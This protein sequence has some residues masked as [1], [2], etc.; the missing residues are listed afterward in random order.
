MKEQILK[1]LSNYLELLQERFGHEK[2][3]EELLISVAEYGDSDIYHNS[4]KESLEKILEVM[5]ID[6]VL[7]ALDIITDKIEGFPKEDLLKYIIYIKNE[8]CLEKENNLREVKEA[9]TE[10]ATP[11]I[12]IWHDIVLT[13]LI[14]TLDSERAQAMAEKLLLFIDANKAKYVILDVTGVPYIDTVVG[15]FLMEMI[16]AVRFLGA[17]VVITG[18]KPDIAHTL[19]KLGVDFNNIIVKRDL[20]TALKY[21]INLIEKR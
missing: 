13:P 6:E 10:L 20:E 4:I 16:K 1:N 9:L 21:V 12:R 15:G 2:I 14:G 8:Y 7:C 11:I 3:W 19:V 18:I 5:K 17:D